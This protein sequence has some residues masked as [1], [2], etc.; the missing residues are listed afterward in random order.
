MIRINRDGDLL[1][2]AVYVLDETAAEYVGPASDDGY[3]IS[4]DTCCTNGP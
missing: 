3:I 2:E 1:G 4:N